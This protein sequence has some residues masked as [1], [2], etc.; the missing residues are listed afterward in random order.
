[1]KNEKFKLIFLVIIFLLIFF[2][3]LGENDDI[4]IP[5]KQLTIKVLNNLNNNP[6]PNLTLELKQVKK[7]SFGF[8]KVFTITKTN[9]NHEGI[10]IIE[11][12]SLSK[13]LVDVYF[14]DKEIFTCSAVIEAKSIDF[15]KILEIRCL[16]DSEKEKIIEKLRK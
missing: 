11:I 1:M 10:A 4:S 7:A 9:L 13:Y 6:I 2:Y 15:K 12:D 14:E 8:L 16:D 5:N 3:F